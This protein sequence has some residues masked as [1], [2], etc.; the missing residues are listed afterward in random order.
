VLVWVSFGFFVTANASTGGIPGTPVYHAPSDVGVGEG[1]TV[2][3]QDCDWLPAKGTPGT[4]GYVYA[5]TTSD[6]DSPGPQPERLVTGAPAYGAAKLLTPTH[7]VGYEGYQL[8]RIEVAGEA[9]LQTLL[10]LDAAARDLEIWSEVVRVGPVEARVS[11]A[12]RRALEAAGLRYEVLIEDLQEHYNTIY[13]VGGPESRGFFDVYRTYDEHVAFLN[14]LA[15]TYPNLAQMVNIGT[16]VQG[17]TM[18][19]IRI[20]GPGENKPGAMYHGAQHG[21]EIMGACVVAYAAEYLLTQYGQIPEITELVDEVEWYLLP[22]MNPDGYVQGNR[23]NANGYDLNRNWGGP[24]CYPNPFS[25][26]ETAAMRDFFLA[27]PNVRAYIDFH[28]AGYMIMW[29]WGYTSAW[30]PDHWTFN[31][32][33]QELRA[34]ILVVRGTDYGHLGPIYST[35]YPVQGG[36]VDYTYG[37]HGI[38]ALTFELGYAHLMPP[39]EILPTCQEI[40]PAMIYLAAWLPAW[41]QDC[42]GNGVH[43]PFDIAWGSSLDCN[44]NGIPDECDL[45]EGSSPDTDGNGVPDECEVVRLYVDAQATGAGHGLDWENACPQLRRALAMASHLGNL[46]AEI[47]VAEGTYRPGTARDAS[48]RLTSG[49]GLYGGFAGGEQELSQ[50][51]PYAHPTVLSGDLLENDAPNDSD[52]C[53]PHYG[54]GCH[55]DACEA[56]VCAEDPSCC[57]DYWGRWCEELAFELCDGVCGGLE[58]NAL[59]VVMAANC[60]ETTVLDGFVVTAGYGCDEDGDSYYTPGLRIAGS[61]P[62]WSSS[63]LVANCT[64]T[65]NRSS[66]PAVAIV[67]GTTMSPSSFTHCAFTLNG[68]APTSSDRRGGGALGARPLACS[69]V[70][71]NCIFTGNWGIASP[72]SPIFC[73]DGRPVHL[74]AD[75]VLANC[76]LVHNCTFPP[77]PGD[78]AR[79]GAGL[80]YV[81]G[82]ITNCILWGNRDS[83]GTDETAQIRDMQPN[84]SCVQ[85][86]TGNL[87]GV[88]NFGDDP[89]FVNALGPDGVAGSPDDDVHLLPLSPCIDTGDPTYDF[90]LEPEPDGGRI[91]I[92]AYGN[93]PEA[94][95]RG[96]LYIEDYALVAQRRVGR[97]TFEYE[98]SV[99]LSNR[100]DR[101]APNVILELL[102]VPEDVTIISG[103]ELTVAPVAAGATVTSVTNFVIQVDRTTPVSPLGFSWR[104]VQMGD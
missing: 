43:D 20:T 17:R 42:N 85:G 4:N 49:V 29:P 34:R 12:H 48:F 13:G 84:Y 82:P 56:L 104:V 10:A 77:N 75:A 72:Y 37:V 61:A 63:L 67:S 59:T 28:S 33:A 94:A 22:I 50:R 93:T 87:G 25:Q 11:P 32:I 102:A 44:E 57:S 1:S 39:D 54:P 23:Y 41:V 3:A 64:F 52:C 90:S 70:V 73:G 19:A 14:N 40:F 21:N 53:R 101:D 92:G 98:M 30:C 62:T 99:I 88:G 51:D 71:N 16:S 15:A 100:S 45:A 47:W 83:V 58:D 55:D 74:R 60:D 76:T 86:W 96:W 36:S 18:W 103:A 80:S 81:G 89:L 2:L 46:V 79:G 69:V 65:K 26:P 95:T 24:G 7:P 27:H 78:E 8:V 68:G 35:I 38:C 5:T 9:Q 91:N 6:P 97:T 66:C 31:D